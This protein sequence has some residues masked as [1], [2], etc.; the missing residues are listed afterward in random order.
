MRK[1]SGGDN[2][3]FEIENIIEETN[4]GDISFYK[5]TNKL[6]EFNRNGRSKTK[7]SHQIKISCKIITSMSKK[8]ILKPYNTARIKARNFLSNIAYNNVNY[9]NVLVTK[10][11]NP[12]F[13]ER[14]ITNQSKQKAIYMLWKDCMPKQIF[15]FICKQENISYLNGKKYFI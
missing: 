13:L 3:N 15:K 4:N 2:V 10:N 14:K 11:L 1:Q 6:N 9:P 5:G 8:V 7:T 12:F